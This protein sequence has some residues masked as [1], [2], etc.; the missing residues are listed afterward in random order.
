MTVLGPIDT[1]FAN[2][3]IHALAETDESPQISVQAHP[4][5]MG[6]DPPKTNTFKTGPELLY[7]GQGKIN[8]NSKLIPNTATPGEEGGIT[9]ASIVTTTTMGHEGL[10]PPTL[11]D[12]NRE[13][14]KQCL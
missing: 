6:R 8:N 3:F 11:E 12:T 4:R 10:K 5:G 2:K 13:D 1:I 9:N 14:D 7:E